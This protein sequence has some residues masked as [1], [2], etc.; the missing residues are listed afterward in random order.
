MKCVYTLPGVHKSILV[1]VCSVC[2]SIAAARLAI[3]DFGQQQYFHVFLV[4]REEGGLI[5][6]FVMVARQT[7][8]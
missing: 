5:T 8:S 4:G 6:L 1:Y 3:Q 7:I 2:V